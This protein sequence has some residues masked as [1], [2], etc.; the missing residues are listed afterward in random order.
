M[1][2]VWKSIK[3]VRD[4]IG[5]FQ[6]RWSPNNQEDSPYNSQESMQNVYKTIGWERSCKCE[7]SPVPAT[8]LD[9]FG[10]SGT[11]GEVC[12]KLGRNAILIEL[13]PDYLSLIEKR[14]N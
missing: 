12:N 7:C 10:G 5:S 8:V 14:I 13:N 3:R 4:I 9:P 6:R 2:G 11:V 1:F